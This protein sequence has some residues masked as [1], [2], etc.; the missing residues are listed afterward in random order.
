MV[1]GDRGPFQQQLVLNDR[2]C[3]LVPVFDGIDREYLW[4]F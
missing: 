3:F 4:T 1:R 2:V